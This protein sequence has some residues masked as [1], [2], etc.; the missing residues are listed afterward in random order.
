[1]S[2]AITR[3]FRLYKWTVFNRRAWKVLNLDVAI[4]TEILWS[5]LALLVIL[6]IPAWF[7]VFVLWR[8]IRPIYYLVAYDG[9]KL[10]AG[11]EKIERANS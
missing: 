5:L 2:A 9:A 6:T 11:L 1:M 10:D 7:P 4:F 3:L 8:L